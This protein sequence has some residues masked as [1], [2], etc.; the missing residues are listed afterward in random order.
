MGA[1]QVPDHRHRGHRQAVERSARTCRPPPTRSNSPDLQV[2]PQFKT[3]IDILQQPEDSSTTRRRPPAPRTRTTFTTAGARWQSG[4]VTDLAGRP[5]GARR[6]DRRGTASWTADDCTHTLAGRRAGRDACGSVRTVAGFMAP[7]LLGLLVFFVYPLVAAVYFSLHQFDLLSAPQLGRAGQLRVHVRGPEPAQAA[8]NTLWFVVVLVPVQIVAALVVGACCS[9]SSAAVRGVLPDDLLPAGAGAR[10][11]PP[12]SRSSSCS[13]PG[14]GPVN[15][16]LELDR[17]RRAAVV[18]RRRTWSKPSLVLL[19]L[20]GIGDIDDHLPGRGA[21]RAAG[22]V[23]G[24]RARRRRRVAAVPATSRCRLSRRCCCSPRSPGSS[25][26]AVLHPGR[27]GRRRSRPARPPWAA[28]PRRQFGYPDGSHLHLPAVALQGRVRPVHA[29]L[30]ERAG[31]WCCSWSRSLSRSCCC[32]ASGRSSGGGT[33]RP[34][35]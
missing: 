22:A 23:R 32:A 2:D 17:H 20:W 31:A 29:R 5:E 9:P 33:G 10:R 18:Q 26:V 1:D 7:A 27:G 6:P 25:D 19:G 4:K 21:G 3:F 14:T 11:W 15:T 35:R 16:L 28:G 12:R 30:R 24:R 8:A 34:C 13:S